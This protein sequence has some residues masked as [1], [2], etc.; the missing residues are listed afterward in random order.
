[1]A[2]V[3]AVTTESAVVAELTAV[4]RWER[5]RGQ[6]VQAQEQGRQSLAEEEAGAEELVP[7]LAEQE[8]EPE[9]PARHE[10]QA[11][12]AQGQQLF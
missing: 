10:P 11:L 5:P 1:M 7:K 12:E 9:Q 6:Q 8:Q 2:E 3:A 4:A